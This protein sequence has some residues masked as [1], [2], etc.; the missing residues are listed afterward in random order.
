MATF[1]TSE[2]FIDTAFGLAGV[3]V[4]ANDGITVTEASG[5]IIFDGAGQVS[6]GKT[7]STS[8]DAGWF[9]GYESGV[10]KTAFDFITFSSGW[11]L[12]NLNTVRAELDANGNLSV[13]SLD[14]DNGDASISSAGSIQGTGF[15]LN[16]GKFAVDNAGDLYIEGQLS[17]GTGNNIYL[18]QTNGLQI[19][20]F[21]V[22][23]DGNMWVGPTGTGIYVGA[24]GSL[25]LNFGVEDLDQTNIQ[26]LSAQ[27]VLMWNGT[28]WINDKV[29]WSDIQ[30]K[31]T[32]LAGF[33]ITDG[34]TDSELSSAVANSSNW[35]TAYGWGDHATAGYITSLTGYATENYVDNAVSNVT[36]LTNSAIINS[37]GTPTLGSGITAS[38]I[39]S[40]IGAA[41]STNESN[42]TT[43]YNWG[44]HASAGYLT[45]HQSLA[46]Y[47]TT[48]ALA[49]EF[50]S[51]QY[52]ETD[53]IFSAWNKS[54]GISITSSQ[55][56]DINFNNFL[57]T[58]SIVSVDWSNITGEPSTL[59][60]Y[61]ISAALDDLSD[62]STAGASTNQALCYTGSGWA[63]YSVL[64][65]VSWNDLNDLPST[66]SEAGISINLNDV[67]DVSTA[68]ANTND[69][70]VKLS[71]GNF[72]FAQRPIAYGVDVKEYTATS[73]Q[74]TFSVN[75]AAN[76]KV[77]V[78]VNGVAID[79]SHYSESPSST[80]GSITFN[81]GLT[82]GD[83]VQLVG[84]TE[85]SELDMVESLNDLTDVDTT[86]AT[87]G[88]VLKK[89]TTG[90]SFGNLNFSSIAN[91]PTTLSGYGITDAATS[92]QGSL[93][94]SAMQPGDDVSDLNNDAGYITRGSV[95]ASVAASASGSGNLSYSSATG[96]FTFTKPD[97][98]PY[99]LKSSLNTAQWDLA[100]GWGNHASAGYA[101]SADLNTGN[102]DT[103][104]GWGDHATAGYALD[105]QLT[106]LNNWNTAYSWGDHATEGYLKSE[107]SHADVVVDGDFT[108]T[109]IMKRGS[110]SGSYSI[111]PDNTT[112]WNAAY[113]WGDH[114]N[115]GYLTA[116]SSTITNLE[117]SA[118]ESETGTW[119]CKLDD[120]SKYSQTVTTGE[121]TKIGD[122]VVA[123]ARINN[124]RTYDS[125]W[126]AM[127]TNNSVKIT[128]LPY[129]ASGDATCVFYANHLE[130]TYYVENAYIAIAKDTNYAHIWWN[131]YSLTADTMRWKSINDNDTD[132]WFTIA[133]L[134]T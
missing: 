120:G 97:L 63:P 26:S 130:T 4:A 33:G 11:E 90:F 42:W 22:D 69:V 37:S 18:D 45:S 92:A 41:D 89:G 114:A 112:N 72:G 53:P 78:S 31:P 7:S 20:D 132:I 84:Y 103:A 67:Q 94:G 17:V 10:P 43:A 122:L 110:S 13:K 100:Y 44:D 79:S 86:G 50:S 34:A 119:T 74:T 30:S 5:G 46:G 24:D 58:S 95:S 85:V 62:V 118:T 40:L 117:S 93:A 29:E 133:Y 8:D 81:N 3:T 87:T 23:I 2:I 1:E 127:T 131:R 14:V 121:Y 73:G 39:K 83:V 75:F 107:T 115:A 76:D 125:S 96:V 47:V 19:G 68:G 38:E 9:I 54:D 52:D 80:A 28:Q 32:T 108:S 116:N 99:Q 113:N 16:N 106:N 65:S 15:S 61:G 59:A 98:S 27:D 6:G 129:T 66:L 21:R 51:F 36:A 105:S 88:Q 71:G 64:S 101:E 111:L 48:S 25:D 124:I 82:T 35:D 77:T 56:S 126:N 12:R 102:W 128:G 49:S 70:L 57:T 55:I 123:S 134:S 60:G 104:Y 109:G 91:T